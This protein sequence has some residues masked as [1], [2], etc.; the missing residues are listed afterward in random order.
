MRKLLLGALLLLSTLGFSQSKDEIIGWNKATWGM[1][2]NELI[3]S[4]PDAVQLDEDVTYSDG[5]FVSIIIPTY[6]VGS[7][8]FKISFQMKSNPI[9][10]A[11][12]LTNVLM[13]LNET[14][15]DST[16]DSINNLLIEKYGE[17]KNRQ[18]SESEKKILWI[19]PKTKIT[20]TRIVM[21][22]IEL[23]KLLIQY[24]Q[25]EDNESTKL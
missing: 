6:K 24:S 19:Y 1:T 18:N 2:E 12:T 4:F 14:P 25:R 17:P 5:I 20:L 11:R 16:F 15:F 8:T 22:N 9:S 21:K 13:E 23:D 3:K 10:K 7:E